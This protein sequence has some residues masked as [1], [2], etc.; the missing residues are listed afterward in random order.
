MRERESWEGNET[1]RS[2]TCNKNFLTISWELRST[3]VLYKLEE[4][5]S[6]WFNLLMGFGEFAY[7]YLFFGH[8]RFIMVIIF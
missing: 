7:V 4:L 2:K 5:A 6:T 8:L 1:N 3:D